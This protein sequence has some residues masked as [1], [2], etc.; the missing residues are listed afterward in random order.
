MNAEQKRR[1][2]KFVLSPGLLAPLRASVGEHLEVDRGADDGYPVI[3][4]YFDSPD[5]NTYWQ[6]VFGVPNR[7]RVRGR[8]Y[9][10]VEGST[11]PGTFIEVKHK[12]DSNTVKRR[13]TLDKE[14]LQR[15]SAGQ[16]PESLL[17]PGEERIL[18][19][20]DG[21]INGDDA[22]P[23]VQI[24]Y[25]RYAYDSGPVGT[26]RV[27][28]D[29]EVSCRFR[30]LPLEPGDTDFELPLIE[31]GASIMEV[32]TIGSVPIW[33]RSIIGKFGLV[34]RGFSKYSRAIELYEQGQYIHSG[35]QTKNAYA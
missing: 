7:R 8:M 15:F 32:K 21:L 17:V 4:E 16:L 25:L 23:A 13:V 26:I 14:E 1:E 31:P 30:L 34:P 2:Y 22:G 29:T 9:G 11:P 3:S 6:K 24:R 35:R 18:R 20:V 27:T 5:R 12:L 10:G 33:F 19:E 28:F